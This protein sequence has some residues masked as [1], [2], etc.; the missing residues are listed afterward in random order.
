MSYYQGDAFRG[1]YYRG[2][3]YRGDPGLFSFVGKALRGVASRLTMGVSETVLNAA[4]PAFKATRPPPPGPMRTAVVALGGTGPGSLTP[5]STLDGVPQGPGGQMMI[6]GPRHRALH[7]NKSTYVTRGGGTSR[8]PQ[9]LLVHPKAT[10][11][12]PSRRMNVGNARAL[13]HALHRISGFAHLARRV[14]SFTH[15]GHGRGRFKFRRK[16]KRLR[17]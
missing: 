5:Y 15:P 1:D 2:D 12:V 14:M 6:A 17:A 10:E 16:T 7:W 9:Q 3:Y 4:I 8:W 13:R 11:P